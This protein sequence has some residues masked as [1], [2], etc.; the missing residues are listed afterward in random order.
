MNP[1]EPPPTRE[2]QP[3]IH[4]N[5]PGVPYGPPKPGNKKKNGIV[6]M[7]SF[8]V[9]IRVNANILWHYIELD[10]TVL[11]KSIAEGS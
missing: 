7:G 9:I 2:Y 4:K 1:E 10:N 6:P 3:N 8:T 11:S 5:I